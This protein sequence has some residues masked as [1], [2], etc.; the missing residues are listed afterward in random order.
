MH[1]VQ[2]CLLY[3]LYARIPPPRACVY[4]HCLRRG[5]ALEALGNLRDALHDY[6]DL[7]RVSP[8]LA[9]AAAA[10]SRL[11]VAL[12]EP[13]SAA[14][15]ASKREARRGGSSG[16]VTNEEMRQVEETKQRVKDV[17]LQKAKVAEAQRSAMHEKKQI[18]L[19]LGQVQKLPEGVRFTHAP[20][21]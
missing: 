8:G 16:S 12:G 7:V 15:T 6:R 20:A 4:D 19:T 18:E 10:V 13:P 9:D 21:A 11:E 2:L 3:R 14:P 5:A 17:A 1:T